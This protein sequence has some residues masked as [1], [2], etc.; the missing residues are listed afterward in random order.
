[1][2]AR[3][4]RAASKALIF[5]SGA[6][7]CGKGINALAS[8]TAAATRTIVMRVGSFTFQILIRR[9]AIDEESPNHSR[10]ENLGSYRVTVYAEITS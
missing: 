5:Q 1:M 9:I 2:P 7:I 4:L 10:E 8:I 6:T 3:G